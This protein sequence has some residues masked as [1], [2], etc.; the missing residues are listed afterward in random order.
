MDNETIKIWKKCFGDVE[1]GKDPFGR[2]VCK[3]NFGKQVKNGWTI[4]HIW[5]IK[6][7]ADNYN[8]GSNNILNKQV[9]HWESNEEKSNKVSGKVN[10]IIYS[11]VLDYEDDKGKNI[12][13][14]KIKYNDQWYWWY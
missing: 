5:P 9:L 3:N 11:V 14:M 4:D 1:H 8:S 2:K 12:G 10:N 7:N 13:K 6:P